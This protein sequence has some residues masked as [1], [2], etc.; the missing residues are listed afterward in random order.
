MS[1]T[2]PRAASA[3]WLAPSVA[4]AAIIACALVVA[5]LTPFWN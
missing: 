1:G 2:S 5:S 3:R 4:A